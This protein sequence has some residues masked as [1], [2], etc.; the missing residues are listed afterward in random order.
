MSSAISTARPMAPVA[1]AIDAGRDVLFD[2]D[3]QGAQQIRNS[4]LGRHTLSIFILPPS[5]PELK[6]RLETP[7]TGRTGRDRQAHA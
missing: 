4:A 2:I 6:R 3:W 5:I 1:E 7:W